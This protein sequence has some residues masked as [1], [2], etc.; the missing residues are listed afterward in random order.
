MMKQSTVIDENMAK[1]I[2]RLRA[3]GRFQ[4]A[5]LTNNFSPPTSA[6]DKAPSLEEELKHLGLEGGGK[7]VRGMFDF[8]V[9]SA[10]VGMR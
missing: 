10:V 6:G 5:A 9:E 3:S 8:F 7:R 2:G 1:A 4:L